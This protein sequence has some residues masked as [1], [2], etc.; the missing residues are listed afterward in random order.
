M[1]LV[2][3]ALAGCSGD[4]GAAGAPGAPAVVAASTATALNIEVTSAT[5]SSPPVMNFVVT[6]EVG[7]RVVGLTP[8]DLRFTIA[9]LM[10]GTSGSPGK[11]QNYINTA[12]S[13][14]TGGYVRG[15]RENNGTLTAHGDG[16][17]TYQFNMD[18]T[19]PAKNTCLSGTCIDADANTIDTTY[20]ASL[21]H[22]V[23]V[24][25]NN[26]ALPLASG[27]Y[28]FRPSD[29]ATSGITTREIVASAK[30]NECHNQLSFHGTRVNTQYCVTCHNPGSTA[31]GQ[32]G[33]VQGPQTV[34]F[35]VMIH[36]IHRGEDLP[37][38]LDADGTVAGSQ[39]GNYGIFGFSGTLEGFGDVVLPQDIRNCTKC[40]DGT[41]GAANA[42][43]QGDNWK[44]QPSRA[45]CGSCHDDVYF[46][47]SPDPAKPWQVTAHPGAPLADDAS[48]AGSTCHGPTSQYLSVEEVHSLPKK[49]K[50]EAAKYQIKINTV[51]STTP[52]ASPV[53]N[54]SIVNP[55]TN[56]PYDIKTLPEFNNSNT[57][58]NLIIGFSVPVNAVNRRDFNNTGSGASTTRP[59]Q[60]L[61]VQLYNSTACPTCANNAA[62]G[63]TAGTYDV[64]LASY[65]TSTGA[66]SWVVPA[67]ATGTGRASIHARVNKVI[68]AGPPASW[69]AQNIAITSVI[70]DFV[71]SGTLTA[72][73]TVVDVAKCDQ[74]HDRL[75]AHGSRTD[76]PGLCVMCHNPDATDIP[77][78]TTTATAVC[79]ASPSLPGN[80]C[81]DGKI[82]EAIDFKRMIHGIHAGAQ[83]TYTGAAAYGF[84][85]KGLVIASADFSDVRFPGILRDCATCHTGTTYALTGN[86]ELPTQNGILGSTTG[87]GADVVSPAAPG[88]D[89]NMA[90]STAVCTSCHDSALA[91]AHMLQIGGAM[92]D[93]A[94]TPTLDANLEQCSI[95]HGPGTV[96]DVKVVHG[97]K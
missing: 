56:A 19:D 74:C 89:L 1:G 68:E 95:C 73:R 14:L 85:E 84:R 62:P 20:N 92:F 88:D 30:C 64:N 52:G 39:P 66:T 60:A 28:D 7:T 78:A 50:A 31:K 71:I 51:T 77:R 49:V 57:R 23:V 27:V 80:A 33:L 70:K 67:G 82:E 55:A 97:V 12:S 87:T 79:P 76:Q 46:T 37:S 32:T 65:V 8:S 38:T 25:N 94:Q 18:P 3:M 43:A 83:T 10:P 36:K 45:A 54:F 24:Q 96:A 4:D 59:A 17:Y 58:L 86:W 41:S 53:V 26:S 15:N 16:S 9:K 91:Q 69:A 2:A 61:N 40:H 81:I 75:V 48:C 47:P 35:K 90:P 34:D 22:R 72:R 5:I 42:T 11:W 6:N 21:T 13:G 29:G 44:T 93:V 63:A